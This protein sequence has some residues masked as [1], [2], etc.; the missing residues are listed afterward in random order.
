MRGLAW[1]GRCGKMVSVHAESGPSTP[2]FRQWRQ[3][4]T[5]LRRAAE[6]RLATPDERARIIRAHAADGLF[7]NFWTSE[8]ERRRGQQIQRRLVASVRQFRPPVRALHARDYEGQAILCWYLRVAEGQPSDRGVAE[9]V[10]R[11]TTF[12]TAPWGDTPMARQKTVRARMWTDESARTTATRGAWPGIRRLVAAVEERLGP[13]LVADGPGGETPVTTSHGPRAPGEVDSATDMVA[14]IR[15]IDGRY[16]TTQQDIRYLKWWQ[17]NVIDRFGNLTTHVTMKVMGKDQRPVTCLYLPVYYDGE[18]RPFADYKI[19]RSQKWQS[20]A[21]EWLPDLGG[22][23]A[24]P[25][26]PLANGATL[27]LQYRFPLPD[28]YREGDE[29]FEWFFAAEHKDYHL[30]I[31]LAPEWEISDVRVSCPESTTRPLPEPIVKD[32][33]IKWSIE[34]PETPRRYRFDWK[35]VRVDHAGQGAARPG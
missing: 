3:L 5:A 35:M 14:G 7:A 30:D 6:Y 24:I 8:P 22:R 2:E 25:I 20:V 28:A 13:M 9:A 26:P 32:H 4:L 19:G 10:G 27:S 34:Y 21:A 29:W 15:R 1:D 11:T 18:A 33:T 12:L 17:S 31:T 16:R 23:F